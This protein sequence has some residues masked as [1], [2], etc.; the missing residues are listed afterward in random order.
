MMRIL[1]F[2]ADWCQPCKVVDPI[3]RDLTQELNLNLEAINVSNQRN[4]FEK[5]GVKTVPT[6]IVEEEG[7]EIKRHTG[8]ISRKKLRDFLTH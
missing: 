7:Q 8:M 5:Y 4:I 2:S 3:V 1:K 6:I